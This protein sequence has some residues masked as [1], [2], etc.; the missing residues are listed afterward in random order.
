MNLFIKQILYQIL[1]KMIKKQKD[2]K[3]YKQS[4]NCLEKW[5]KER[6][7]GKKKIELN[8]NK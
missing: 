8:K 7:L 1:I 2:L 4:Q 5:K 3:E 6:K